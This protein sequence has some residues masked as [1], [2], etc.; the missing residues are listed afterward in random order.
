MIILIQLR[1][2]PSFSWQSRAYANCIII[3]LSDQNVHPT[4][5]NYLLGHKWYLHAV[6]AA[7]WRIRANCGQLTVNSANKLFIARCASICHNLVTIERARK[8]LQIRPACHFR[9]KSQYWKQFLKGIELINQVSLYRVLS[10]W[11]STINRNDPVYCHWRY[12]TFRSL[13][14]ANYNV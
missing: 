6:A 5:I 4:L 2:W 1:V 12:T 13:S 7:Q 10:H 8:F 14:I 11:Q 3:Y 9:P